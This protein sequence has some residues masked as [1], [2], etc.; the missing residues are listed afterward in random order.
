MIQNVAVYHHS[1]WFTHTSASVNGD[2]IFSFFNLKIYKVHYLQLDI[3]GCN[4]KL[5]IALKLGKFMF[6]PEPRTDKMKEYVKMIERLVKAGNKILIITGGGETARKYIKA[7]RTLKVDE[8]TCDQFGIE[9]SRINAYLLISALV[10]LAYPEVPT[11]IRELKKFFHAGKVVVIGGL[12]PGH[13]TMTVGALAAEAIKAD[14]YIIASDVDGIYSED[15]KINPKAEKFDVV[16][17]DM[18]FKMA[19]EQKVLAGLYAIDPLAIKIIERSKIP[20][21]FIN[22]DEP[23]NFEKVLSNMKV[24]TFIKSSGG[25][26]SYES[27]ETFRK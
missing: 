12:T 14:L 15:P 21:Y 23:G 16:T 19:T 25:D 9:I 3:K 13:S 18:L 22:G 27:D 11:T 26:L 5:I 6:S 20:T 2:V 24:G 8:A 10:G 4:S 17:T 1:E 7:A